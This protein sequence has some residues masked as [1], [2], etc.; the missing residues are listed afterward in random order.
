M[1]RSARLRALL[2]SNAARPTVD[3]LGTAL[4]DDV[5]AWLGELA[6]LEGMPFNAIVPDARMLPPESI[7]FFY[8]DDNWLA[9][10]RD[11]ALSVVDLSEQ[12]G[13]MLGVHRPR[14]TDDMHAAA[15]QVRV[16]RRARARS[17]PGRPPLAAASVVR[18]TDLPPARPW[19]GFLLRSAAVSDW[20]GLAI[21]GYRE[22][23]GSDQLQ[24][25]RLERLAP[26]VLLAIFGG[27]VQQ[28][29]IAKPAQ[30]L[31]FGVVDSAGTRKRLEDRTDD[32]T[33]RVYLRGL[34]GSLPAGEQLSDGSSVTVPLRPVVNG[35]KVLA[36]DG[37]T[38]LR[39]LLNDT[40][41]AK[42]GS[43]PPPQVPLVQPGAFGLEMVAG[44]ELQVFVPNP[45]PAPPARA[46]HGS[47]GTSAPSGAGSV[48]VDDLRAVLDHGA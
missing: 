6:L 24:L 19:T 22:A 8:L 18:T 44:A 43:E 4:P 39:Q 35:R 1:S 29:S 9:A 5:V 37:A 12:D 31:H 23:G 26:T 11:G 13:S 25:L 16:R 10:L 41:T 14:I 46:R 47:S 40:L 21:K 38:G 42:Y 28:V 36:I 2:T 32:E 27:V 17:R 7:R 48:T 3:A 45:L 34:G 20:P 30:G 15:A 33:Y